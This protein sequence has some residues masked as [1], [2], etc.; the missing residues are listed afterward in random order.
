MIERNPI[1]ERALKEGSKS[2]GDIGDIGGGTGAIVK[3]SGGGIGGS[4]SGTRSEARR[5]GVVE[6]AKQASALG[7]EG[8]YAQEQEEEMYKSYVEREQRT[9]AR[10]KLGVIAQRK[11]LSSGEIQYVGITGKKYTFPSETQLSYDPSYQREIRGGAGKEEIKERLIRTAI[12]RREEAARKASIETGLSIRTELPKKIIQGKVERGEP[13]N[14]LE[15][16]QYSEMFAE[17][18]FKRIA[19]KTGLEYKEIDGFV[20]IPLATGTLTRQKITSKDA[21]LV[22][23]GKPTAQFYPEFLKQWYKS[24]TQIGK[25]R[26]EA[27]LLGMG[28]KINGITKEGVVIIQ[29]GTTLPSMNKIERNRLNQYRAIGEA[30]TWLTP[31]SEKI[32]KTGKK[33]YPTAKTMFETGFDVAIIPKDIFVNTFQ[34]IKKSKMGK[35]VEKYIKKS[36]TLFAYQYGTKK[37]EELFM[38]LPSSEPL[39]DYFI[40][41]SKKD[42]PFRPT[43]AKLNIIATDFLSGSYEEIR[44]RPIK[45]GYTFGGAYLLGGLL[46]FTSRFKTVQKIMKYSGIGLGT[47]YVGSIGLQTYILPLEE[48]GGFLG[49]EAIRS[50]TFIT[51]FGKGYKEFYTPPLAER[52]ARKG[53]LEY[54]G[55][56]LFEQ[57]VKARRKGIITEYYPEIRKV[58]T[59]G[60]IKGKIEGKKGRDVFGAFT[61]DVL[62]DR[63]YEDRFIEYE[64]ILFRRQF[65]AKETIIPKQ[66]RSITQIFELGKKPRQIGLFD[67]N[68]LPE[69]YSPITQGFEKQFTKQIKSLTPERTIELYIGKKGQIRQRTIQTG[70]QQ[71]M[72]RR[73]RILQERIAITAEISPSV[74]T[75]SYTHVDINLGARQTR[76]QKNILSVVEYRGDVDKLRYMTKEAKGF[77]PFRKIKVNEETAFR[78]LY[79]GLEKFEPRSAKYL[80]QLYPTEMQAGLVTEPKILKVGDKTILKEFKIDFQPIAFIGLEEQFVPAL[81]TKQQN[82]RITQEFKFRIPTQVERIYIQNILQKEISKRQKEQNLFEKFLSGKYTTKKLYKKIF[83]RRVPVVNRRDQAL[84]PNYLKKL[85]VKAR[86]K[87]I[88]RNEKYFDKLTKRYNEARKQITKEYPELAKSIQLG[89][90]K[91]GEVKTFQK[92]I[93]KRE[94]MIDITT[95]KIKGKSIKSLIKSI[96]Q[97]RATTMPKPI[98]LL[99]PKTETKIRSKTETEKALKQFSEQFTRA[100]LRS[101][102]QN[103]LES[104]LRSNIKS[105][106]RSNLQS[107]L[108][109][110]LRSNLKQNLRQ[111]L[112]IQ[113]QLKT[114][115]EMRITPI[116]ITPSHPPSPPPSPPPPP[117]PFIQFGFE[118]GKK[119]KKKKSKKGVKFRYQPSLVPVAEKIFG[120]RPKVLSGLGIRPL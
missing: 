75:Q 67:R 12:Q 87:N 106:L 41:E 74:I 25:A 42:I 96:T 116:N 119:K 31:V 53:G 20:Q 46:G 76:P 117:P 66:K 38:K 3:S 110:N 56:A 1:I 63:I 59:S 65:L 93:E 19:K 95:P 109:S 60:I 43:L 78:D 100:N 52:L 40:T 58:E 18:E 113:Q 73:L 98:P 45:T 51:G 15:R 62:R 102:L 99:K 48:K 103:N 34:D 68:I 97:P 9:K 47:L 92:L 16:Q 37:I 112:R 30:E 27:V 26:G 107:N 81:I 84:T 13:L 5:L 111:N 105:N 10:A 71:D 4:G 69:Y 108:R 6:A 23:T 61:E 14:R 86:Q 90:A 28:D 22:E 55:S 88:K 64:G 36:P 17:A 70:K 29:Q 11:V 54:Q 8:T 21:E 94:L 83:P 104:N 7:K 82:V 91:E 120:A 79:F 49:K 72:L 33:Y 89:T 80:R 2:G 118:L 85:N 114:Q 50:A 115:I 24:L 39:R 44:Q 77:E 35:G 57:R 101:N 32:Y